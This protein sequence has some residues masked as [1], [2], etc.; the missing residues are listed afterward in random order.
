[1][2]E[3]LHKRSCTESLE[4]LFREYE[5]SKTPIEVNFRDLVSW[6]PYKNRVSHFI[7]PY[8][9]KLLM[10]I[11]YFFINNNVLSQENDHVIDPFCGSGTTALESILHNRNATGIDINPLAVLISKVKTT[12]IP[13][14]NLE[15]S[16]QDLLSDIDLVKGLQIPNVVNIDY[17]FDDKTI[18]ILSS[19]K[20]SIQKVENTDIKNFFLVCFSILVQKKSL[21]D[22]N[23]SVPVKLN[24]G[25]DSKSER[26]KKYEQKK[27][28]EIRN[29][30]PIHLFKKIIDKTKSQIYELNLN[31]NE[32]VETTILNQDIKRLENGDLKKNHYQLAITSPPYAGAQK[33]IRSSSLSL[34]W[35]GYTNTK[36]LVDYKRSSI[37]REDYRVNEIDDLRKTGIIKVDNFIDEIS[38]INAKRAKILSSYLNE[39]RISLQNL[40]SLIKSNGYLVIILGNN[41]ICNKNFNTQKY[42]SQI[43]EEQGFKK[44]LTLVDVIKSR[45]LMTKRNKTANVINREWIIVF[46]K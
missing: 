17:W 44:E 1:M 34:G 46:K 30:D 40:Y 45:G 37:G 41:Q 10:H 13:R 3:L 27:L 12:P 18:E 32:N 19:I 25:K 8:P 9:A 33:Y 29:R 15:E 16:I 6:I 22:P 42:I 20:A 24:P 39:M 43:A 21:A 36:S 23:V 5:K 11:P 26:R 31:L 35:L 4:D 14:E 2:K 7:H 38:K 28:Q